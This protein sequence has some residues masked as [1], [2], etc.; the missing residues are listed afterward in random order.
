MKI[1]RR[2]LRAIISEAIRK[3][4][5][6]KVKPEEIDVM[7]QAARDETGIDDMIGSEKAEKL[8]LRAQEPGGKDQVRSIYQAL[9]SDEPDFTSAKE[10]EFYQAQ[11]AHDKKIY[12]DNLQEV[13]EMLLRGGV[14]TLNAIA[15]IKE[16]GMFRRSPVGM[17]DYYPNMVPEKILIAGNL[18]KEASNDFIPVLVKAM[19]ADSTT[20]KIR[21]NQGLAAVRGYAGGYFES[22]KPV[23]PGEPY[24]GIAIFVDYTHPNMSN[25]ALR[26]TIR[27]GKQLKQIKKFI[28]ALY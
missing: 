12:N 28:S 19:R 22:D 16:L 11:D 6:S 26:V 1:S 17:L 18:T 10:E 24:G 20:S 27:G 21:F 13:S 9:G 8:R 14:D 4:I 15:M 25:A 3:P 2:Q 7:R 5:F 23:L